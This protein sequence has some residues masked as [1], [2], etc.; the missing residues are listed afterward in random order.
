MLC[1]TSFIHGGQ[2]QKT[3]RAHEQALAY[4][5]QQEQQLILDNYLESIDKRY[6]R[7]HQDHHHRKD[8]DSGAVKNVAWNFLMNAEPVDYIEE[9]RRQ[10]DAIYVLG[11]ADL[12]SERLLQKHNLPLPQSKF[13]DKSIIDVH[14]S[15][16]FDVNKSTNRLITENAA[17]VQHNKAVEATSLK[18]LATATYFVQLLKCTQH[19]YRNRLWSLIHTAR[20]N[21]VGSVKS[22]RKAMGKTMSTA[23]NRMNLSGQGIG[24]HAI[25]FMYIFAAT[26][27]ANAFNVLRLMVKA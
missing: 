18:I 9:Q 16:E 20:T 10:R 27:M 14:S 25:N 19:T 4:A 8:N 22:S 3:R 7:L 2:R 6:K 13:K 15:Q 23:A 21:I 12:A 5:E 26:L 24:K 1:P 11:L 17:A